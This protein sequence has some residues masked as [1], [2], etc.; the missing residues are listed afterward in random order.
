MRCVV[1]ASIG[2]ALLSMSGLCTQANWFLS[3]KIEEAFYWP[4]QWQ[5][6]EATTERTIGDRFDIWSCVRDD[7]DKLRKVLL[8]GSDRAV[9]DPGA[10]S[11]RLRFSD[12]LVIL[13]DRNGVVQVGGASFRL[14]KKDFQRLK[15]ILADALPPPP[16]V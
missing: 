13:M 15:L 9:L 7:G 8:S 6:I 4:I 3:P 14:S 11:L 2:I 1:R 10:I 5:S 16:K 12:G